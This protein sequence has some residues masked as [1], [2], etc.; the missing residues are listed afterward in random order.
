MIRRDRPR[1]AARV[2]EPEEVKLHAQK[3]A[4]AIHGWAALEDVCRIVDAK[5]KLPGAY[6][7]KFGSGAAPAPAPA[8]AA[9]AEED[10]GGV[11]S[12]RVHTLVSCNS[13][14]ARSRSC[15]GRR[16]VGLN[17]YFLWSKTWSKTSKESRVGKHRKKQMT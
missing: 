4:S 1:A 11:N 15:C 2:L 12:S 8:A 3:V 16:P 7:A 10:D 9:A 5:A 17:V 13:S 6:A 14:C